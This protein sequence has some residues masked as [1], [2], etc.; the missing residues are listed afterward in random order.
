MRVVNKE[1]RV[2]PVEGCGSAVWATKN[3]WLCLIKKHKRRGEIWPCNDKRRPLG[4]QP[5]PSFMGRRVGSAVMSRNLKE[6]YRIWR[7]RVTRFG[8]ARQGTTAVEFA[9]IAPAFI[10]LLVAVLETAVFLFAQSSLQTAAVQAGRLFMTG[11][12]QTLSQA[13]FKTQ[14]CQ[15][16]LPSVFNCNSL[17]IVVQSYSSFASANTSAPAMYNSQGQA[18]AT[19]AYNP[20]NPGQIMVVQLVYPWSVVNGPLGFVLSN[21]PNNAAEM[22]GIS[23]FRVE[24]YGS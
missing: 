8:V 17:I 12:A 23:A 15:N 5:S 13:A 3:Q 22:M 14:I 2:N 1:T 7:A 18:V 24:P 21:L 10:A 20:G 16:Y 6:Q 19:W 9:L 4:I 11:Q